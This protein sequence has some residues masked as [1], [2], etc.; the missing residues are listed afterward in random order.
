[1]FRFI[2]PGLLWLITV[3]GL[4][5]TPGSELQR[6]DWF[7]FEFD[8]VVHTGIYALLVHLWLTGFK[9]QRVNRFFRDKAYPLVISLA[10][11]IGVVIEFLQGAFI[12]GRVFDIYDIIAN[13]VGV[14]VG[15]CGFYF[16]YR[17]YY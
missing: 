6:T 9:R 5:L 16:L 10:I 12:Y 13:V 7:V 17:N 3:V 14:C 2:L 11:A 15:T 4:S 8:K 1:M